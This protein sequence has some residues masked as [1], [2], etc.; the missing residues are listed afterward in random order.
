MCASFPNLDGCWSLSEPGKP[1]AKTIPCAKIILSC[2]C[3]SSCCRKRD[4]QGITGWVTDFHR[5]NTRYTKKPPYHYRM[6][7]LRVHVFGYL[8][9]HTTTCTEVCIWLGQPYVSTGSQTGQSWLVAQEQHCRHR[10]C[11]ALLPRQPSLQRQAPNTYV[12]TSVM[13]LGL[14]HLHT[15]AHRHHH[16]R[17]CNQHII[18]W[19]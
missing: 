9:K 16:H 14:L 3:L 10:F 12:C 17:P 7:T 6:L 19:S 2:R 5:Q 8:M 13:Q 15:G 4:R 11:I 1:Q 18:R